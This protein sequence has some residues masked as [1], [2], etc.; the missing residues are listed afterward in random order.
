MQNPPPQKNPFSWFL[1]VFLVAPQQQS[2]TP[3]PLYTPPSPSGVF[4]GLGGTCSTSSMPSP[5]SARGSSTSVSSTSVCRRPRLSQRESDCESSEGAL[6]LLNALNS[7]DRGLKVRFSL[8]TIAFDRESAQ[9]SQI[10]SSQGK[11]APSNP[12][13]HYFVRLATSRCVCVCV[14]VSRFPWRGVNLWGGL[15]TSEEVW[16]VGAPSGRSRPL[17]GKSGELL[18]NLW[19]ASGEVQGES[20][21][22]GEVP[23]GRGKSDS[24]SATCNSCLQCALS[25]PLPSDTKLLLT[26][27]YFEIIIFGKL[28]I[29]RVIP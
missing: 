21:K 17:L 29:S 24:L 13:P 20:R 11:N 10:L 8:A 18:E 15:A 4:S 28:R 5:S 7:E 22:S 25:V 26:K 14:C 3:I 1:C 2:H 16:L 27:N 23:E 9:M 19:I 6:R 12:Y